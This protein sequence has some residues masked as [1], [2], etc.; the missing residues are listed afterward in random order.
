MTPAA[1]VLQAT[2]VSV[3]FGGVYALKNVDLA[4]EK[5]RI[6]ALIGPN[7]AGKTTLVNCLSGFLDPDAG[8]VRIGPVNATRLPAHARIG[9]GLGRTFQH[10]RLFDAMTALENVM[11]GLSGVRPTPLL[12]AMFR[13]PSM[14]TRERAMRARAYETLDFMGLAD[15]ADR[16]AG[17]LPYGERKLLALARALVAE[18][19]ALLLD[20]PA[21]GLNPAETAGLADRI[22]AL[23]NQ[24]LGILL[25]EHDMSLVMRVSDRV[26]VLSSGVRIAHGPPATVRVDPAVVEAY[27]G[28][29]EEFG[30][31]A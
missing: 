11:A 28:G 16:A 29:A 25:I 8:K 17:G 1:P 4:L 21:A 5:G 6:H 22:L 14:R 3:A 27:L 15:L 20:E 2:N 23:R 19:T 12:A 13:F 9:L 24:G 30:L 31:H 7:G 18:P 26:T 10:L